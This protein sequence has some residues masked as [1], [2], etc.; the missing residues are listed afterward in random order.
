MQ[1]ADIIED[2]TIGYKLNPGESEAAMQQFAEEKG[3]EK[4]G[5][6]PA[7]GAGIAAGFIV[8]KT[9]ERAGISS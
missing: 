8:D 9:A 6:P 1:C 2:V 7:V 5:L 3:F 4:C